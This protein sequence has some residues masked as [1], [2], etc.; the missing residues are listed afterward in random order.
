MDVNNNIKSTAP[1]LGEADFPPLVI[2]GEKRQGKGEDS[3]FCSLEAQGGFIGVFDGS[4]GSGARTY[5][6]FGGRTGAYV[7]SRAAAEAAME[8]FREWTVSADGDAPEAKAVS[9]EKLKNKIDAVLGAYHKM[10]ASSS[11]LRSSLAK[12]FPTTFAGEVILPD[13]AAAEKMRVCFAWS[14][15]SRCYML[16]SA[17]L[18]QMS[19]DDLSIKDAYLNLSEDA[20]MLNVISASHS[21]RINERKLKIKKPCVLFAATDGCF[22]Y[23]KSP[24]EFERMLL[25]TL[26]ASTC[27]NEWREKLSE[28]IDGAAGD[29]FTLCVLS[30]GFGSFERLKEIFAE[31]LKRL[32]EDYPSSEV[33]DQKKTRERWENYRK[34]YE[35]YQ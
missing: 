22:G 15:D 21:Y 9:I 12:E 1:L 26:A 24:M 30:F 18:H 23:V 13:E 11:G 35:K 34:E 29:D 32:E 10:T 27:I 3:Y 25:T 5:P 4:G 2:C 19:V 17:G 28:A 33:T 7:G 20:P 16:D 31:R 14:G 8:W 6:E